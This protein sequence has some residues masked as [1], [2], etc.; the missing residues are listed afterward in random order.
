MTNIIKIDGVRSKKHSLEG[1]NG[2]YMIIRSRKAILG[3]LLT[4][5]FDY[6]FNNFFIYFTTALITVFL[7]ET[8]IYWKQK[9]V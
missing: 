1:F 2:M 4:K 8:Y 3:A 5:I 7:I 6:Y 9:R